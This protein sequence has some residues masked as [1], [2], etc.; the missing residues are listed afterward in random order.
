MASSFYVFFF[1]SFEHLKVA[2]NNLKKQATKKN[3]GSLAYVKGGLSTFF[4]AQDALSG[5]KEHIFFWK[6]QALIFQ[7]FI[8][9]TPSHVVS[10]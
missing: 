1:F 8:P 9:S 7:L 6:V 4:E 3:E 5:E 2:A 10:Q